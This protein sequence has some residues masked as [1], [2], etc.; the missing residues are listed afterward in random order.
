MTWENALAEH[1]AVVRQFT[2]ALEAVPGDRWHTVPDAGMW[3]AAMLALHVADSYAFGVEAAQGRA[4]MV[5]RTPRPVAWFARTV[6][7]PRLLARET[8]PR[9]A[10]APAEVVPDGAR[11]QA[12]DQSQMHTHLTAVATRAAEALREARPDVRITHA[13]FGPLRPLAALRLL[14]AHTRHHADGMRRR[15]LVRAGR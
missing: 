5:R 11:A 14:S 2:R 15:A 9:G 13:Y 7:L 12:F 8:F 10:Q 3:S 4:A 1:T 6:L